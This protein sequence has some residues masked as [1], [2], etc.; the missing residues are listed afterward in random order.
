MFMYSFYYSGHVE[1]IKEAQAHCTKPDDAV[2][3]V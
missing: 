2:Y 1:P 3:L